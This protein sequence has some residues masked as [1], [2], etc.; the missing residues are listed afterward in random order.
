[1]SRSDDVFFF[2]YQI[3]VKETSVLTDSHRL[4]VTSTPP[5][6]TKVSI[7]GRLCHKLRK[8]GAQ[9]AILTYVEKEQPGKNT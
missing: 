2:I 1:M 8:E 5:F 9:K 3:G 7:T 4:T 6:P